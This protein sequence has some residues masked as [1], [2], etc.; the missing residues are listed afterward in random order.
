MS[1]N[2]SR[3]IVPISFTEAPPSPKPLHLVYD[4]QDDLTHVLRDFDELKIIGNNEPRALIK[5]PTTKQLQNIAY[6]H[7]EFI[8]NLYRDGCVMNLIH[9]TWWKKWR[10]HVLF[11]SADPGSIIN[12]IDDDNIKRNES[13][14][15]PLAPFIWDSLIG[16]YGGGPAVYRHCISFDRSINIPSFCNLGEQNEIDKES[17]VLRLEQYFSLFEIDT[18]DSVNS[19][20]ALRQINTLS[21]RKNNSCNS[22]NSI[23]SN[24]S[25]NSATESK[26]GTPNRTRNNISS[27]L[28]YV[29]RRPSKFLCTKC[30]LLNYCDKQCQISHWSSYHKK[31]CDKGAK[32][33][34]QLK[35]LRGKVGL[36]NLGN[37]C[38]LSS[39]LQC[40]AHI[41][42]LTTYF[43]SNEYVKE[44]NEGNRDGTGGLLV[45][46]YCEL[47]KQLW[48]G[49][50]PSV[51]PTTFK[52][53]LGHLNAEYAGFQQQDV[54]E[55]VNYLIDKF[56]EDLNRV[57]VKP[58][59]EKPEGNGTNDDLISKDAWKLH[60]SRENSIV[61]DIVGG[62]IRS[63]LTCPDCKKVS[64]SFDYFQTIE[65]AIPRSTT[66]TFS[67]IYFPT[68]DV[69]SPPK[70]PILVS[71]TLDRSA[72]IATLKEHLIHIIQTNYEVDNDFSKVQFVELDKNNIIGR[73]LK[74]KDSISTI[75]DNTEIGAYNYGPLKE[76]KK[77]TLCILYQ[78]KIIPTEKSGTYLTPYVSYPMI[79]PVDSNWTTNRLRLHI[80]SYVKRFIASDCE[81]NSGGSKN[82]DS[83]KKQLY[84]TA[85]SHLPL[86]M[87]NLDGSINIKNRHHNSNC[88][89]LLNKFRCD[90]D[91]GPN[92][93]FLGNI[94]P[95]TGDLKVSDVHESNV[96]LSV[97]WSGEW[98]KIL[99]SELIDSVVEDKSYTAHKTT[100]KSP[101]DKIRQRRRSL[102]GISLEH[103]L[104]E[105]TREETLD[106]TNTWYCSVCKKHQTA[107]K[108]LTFWK[109]KLPDVLILLLKRFEYRDSRRNSGSG[110]SLLYGN[111]FGIGTRDKIETMVDFPL[112]ELNMDPYCGDESNTGLNPPIYDLFAVTNHYGRMGFGH[113]TACARDLW[114][115]CNIS[116]SKWQ[117]YDDESVERISDSEVST[118]AAYILFYKRR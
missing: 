53:L 21:I 63:Q 85:G 12:D 70:Q 106:D 10:D 37:S 91:L 93:R 69:M 109:E 83:G 90:G 100:S 2:R 97:D 29:C 7:E 25:D 47:L 84:V 52:K 43:L 89:A 50:V 42:P 95:A 45:K 39:C 40:L 98:L 48:F 77:T 78:R 15:I 5:P 64:V 66:R 34:E 8:N 30:H 61:Q 31:F 74:F 73:S 88:P 26:I 44:I 76:D 6:L 102:N 75:P 13:D 41:I 116:D 55:L 108:K 16:W 86:R 81:L 56:H 92:E 27:V 80:F 28:C 38:Y 118:N 112:E 46:E 59:T 54:H 111:H 79:F 36:H 19:D 115:N 14:Y 113:Y 110:P 4:K 117:Q 105:F 62:Q 107:K 23:D 99:D 82:I 67:V 51:S 71:V 18:S 103:C 20:E 114:D 3:R 33:M 101:N 32:Y 49:A 60:S 24:K 104:R 87:V 68:F 96:M 57:R 11:D 9:I 72:L 1:I 65:I 35:L 17:V 22:L 94:Y 58:Y